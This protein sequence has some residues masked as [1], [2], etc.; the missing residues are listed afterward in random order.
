MNR[1][2]PR[3]FVFGIGVVIAVFTLASGVAPA[4]TH[5]HD[6]S[7]IRRE[8]FIDIPTAVKV[9]FYAV[10]STMLLLVGWLAS[11]RVRNYE[12]GGSDDRRTTRDNVRRRWC[13]P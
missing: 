6:A 8:V 3:Q 10:T 11:Q 4:L 2:R 9:A 12:R 7:A 13:K 1:V 5:G